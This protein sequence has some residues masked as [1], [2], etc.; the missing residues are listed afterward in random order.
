MRLT[1]A[2][3]Q[4]LRLALG[5][6][7]NAA[8]PSRR[9]PRPRRLCLELLED[10][11][12]PSNYTAA[13]VADLINDINAANA[14]GGSNTIALVAGTTFTLSAVDNTTDGATGLPVIAAN[15]NLTLAG[16]GDTLARSAHSGTPAFRLLDVAAGASLTLSNLTLQGGLA[17]GAGVAAAGGAI[18]N[19]GT[20]L[21]TGVTLQNNSAQGSAGQS[22]GGAGQSAAGGG[23]YSGGALTL[24]GCTL[25]NNQVLGGQGYGQGGFD[26]VGGNGGNGFGGGLYVAGGSANLSAVTL[27]ANT[28][29]GGAGGNG[30]FRI[31]ESKRHIGLA[32]GNG[33]NGFGGGLY[34]AGGTVSLGSTTVD[35][36]TVQGGTGGQGGTNGGANGTP[37]LGEGGGLYLDPAAAVCL[38]AF[39]LAHFKSNQASTSDPDIHGS[40]TT[41]P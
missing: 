39:T 7:G 25:Q 13:T 24:H 8:R 18:Y 10:R 14:A 17:F 35:H 1:K 20:L 19:Q 16:S 33:G 31:D 3:Q 29:K 2:W 34:A 28:A 38:D 36:N 41:C 32:G 9:R 37:G 11:H 30:G 40:Y 6:R 5:S 23:I 26:V 21:L 27:Y 22:N 15:D 12:L 4:L